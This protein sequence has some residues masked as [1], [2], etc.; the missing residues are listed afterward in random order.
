MSSRIRDPLFAGLLRCLGTN[1][2]GRLPP[3]SERTA[4]PPSADRS[5][6]GQGIASAASLR[7]SRSRIMLHARRLPGVRRGQQ[8]HRSMTVAGEEL[9]TRPAR[10]RAT[11]RAVPPSAGTG[12]PPAHRL[13][14]RWPRRPA[15]CAPSSWRQPTLPGSA[16][17]HSTVHDAVD[18]TMRNDKGA[19]LPVVKTELGFERPIDAGLH[20]YFHPVLT[21]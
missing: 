17:R 8:L 19:T 15:P 4:P 11:L 21:E 18:T 13:S 14:R 20:N 12:A 6:I 1:R 9:A 3:T 5:T 7:A 16:G 2:P 10:R